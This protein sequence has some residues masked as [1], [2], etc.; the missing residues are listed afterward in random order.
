MTVTAKP[1][2]DKPSVRAAVLLLAIKVGRHLN[3]EALPTTATAAIDAAG[4]SR[5]QAYEVL[6]RLEACADDLFDGAGRPAAQWLPLDK[7]FELCAAVRDFLIEH[8]G[9]VTKTGQRH[10][11]HDSFRAFVVGMFAPGGMADGIPVE[12]AAAA[13]GVPFGTL[14]DWLCTVSDPPPRREPSSRSPSVPVSVP[15][16]ATIQLEYAD[17]QGTLSS[18]CTYVR[19]ELGMDYGR[20]FITSVLVLSGLHRPKARQLDVQAPWSRGTYQTLFPGVQWLGDGTLVKLDINGFVFPFNLEAIVDTATSATV[21]IHVSSAEDVEAVRGAYAHGLI[22]TDGQ[23]PLSLMLDNKPCNHSQQVESGCP[24]ATILHSTPGRG[25]AKAAV[26]GSFG[27]FQQG[28]PDLVIRGDS[29]EDVAKDIVRLV[30]TAWCIGRNGR[31]RRKLGGLSPAQLYQSYNASDEDLAKAHALIL[32]LK[33]KEQQAAQTRLRRADPARLSILHDALVELGIDDPEDRIAA[34]LAGYALPAILQGIAIFKS[35]RAMGNV[36]AD[37]EPHRY[38]GGI[39][40]NLDHRTRTQN[41]SDELLKLR[42][43]HSA[44][45]RETFSQELQSLLDRTTAQSRP[46][47]ALDQALRSKTLFAY[48]YW[49]IRTAEFLSQLDPVTAVTTY[50]HLTRIVAAHFSIPLERREDIISR[51]GAAVAI[52]HAA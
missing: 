4:V 9:A 37:A 12:K 38:L 17:W 36:P 51:L 26:E 14:K 16:L 27:L 3:L 30:V 8:P 34:S 1:V 6:A 24:G 10:Q 32:R 7:S 42:L 50:R 5:S 13:L 21:G 2:R 41:M 33:D 19:D 29:V 11:F 35:L 20:T 15:D 52:A 18:F 43:K 39:I 46:G 40:R 44:M 49:S 28:C 45:L 31:P 22:S 25:Q 23:C 48:R 47:A